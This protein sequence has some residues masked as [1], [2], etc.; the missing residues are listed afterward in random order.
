MSTPLLVSTDW[1]AQHL[2]D[3]QV[4]VVDVRWYLIDKTRDGRTEYL[5]GHIPG[6]VFVDVDHDLAAPF[7]QGPGR[8]PLPQ[9]EVFAAAMARAGIGDETYVIAYDDMGGANA[10]RLWW[11]LRYV[12][13]ERVSLLDG[14][15]SQWIKEGRP[16]ETNT[17][18]VLPAQLTPGAPHRDWVVDKE[19][20]GRLAHEPR[21]LVLDVRAAERY[22][23]E[24]EPIDPRAGHVPGAKSAPYA[25]N[26]HSL[27]DPRFLEPARLRARFEALGA[28][29]AEQIVSYC[30]SGINACQ[31]IFALQLAG[32]D[33]ALLYEGAW[34]D[35]SRDPERAAA[36]GPNPG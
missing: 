33:N 34:S 36:V 1:L 17:P 4:R 20:V 15:I 22:R 30:G 25:G 5:R 27:E 14:G 3:P 2:H 29:E 10:A 21:S 8:H 9:P 19:T 18:E 13:H 28:G 31:N 23:G 16:L 12:G 6:A 26:V 11:L 35:W 7:G 24:I 32:F